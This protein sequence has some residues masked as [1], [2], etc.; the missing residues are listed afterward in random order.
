VVQEAITGLW[1][2]YQEMN[3]VPRSWLAMMMT[4]VRRRAIDLIRS[5]DVRRAGFS[6][7]DED[8]TFQPAEPGD[9]AG[10]H[11]NSHPVRAALDALTDEQQRE[12]L[13]RIY[14]ED[15]SQAQVAKDL[16]LTPGR[17][18]QIKQAALNEIASHTDEEWRR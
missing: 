18:T 2:K 5:A 12:V 11:A 3:E 17:I 13:H 4:A 9:F 15:Q 8:V 1:A 6:M 14:Y 10:D 16:G 7:D